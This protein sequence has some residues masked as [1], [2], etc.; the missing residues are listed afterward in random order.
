MDLYFI[1]HIAAPLL[2]FIYEFGY[3]LGSSCLD[4]LTTTFSFVTSSISMEDCICTR[5]LSFYQLQKEIKLAT[6]SHLGDRH[7]AMVWRVS[8][9]VIPL[10]VNL[11]ESYYL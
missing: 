5:E 6:C 10:R 9:P 7:I 11:H 3:I 4:F 1:G 8:N 2:D